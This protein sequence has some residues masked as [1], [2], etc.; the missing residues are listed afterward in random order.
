MRGSTSARYQ[1]ASGRETIETQMEHM[2]VPL[3]PD[4]GSRQWTTATMASN[5]SAAA[6]RRGTRGEANGRW[7]IRA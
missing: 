2:G 5:Y 4:Q 6:R 1:T 3:W 7:Q